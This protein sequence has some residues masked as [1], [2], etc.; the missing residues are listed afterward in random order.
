MTNSPNEFKSYLFTY[1]HDGAEWV[2]EIQAR[3]EK[4][5]IARKAKI[6][7]ARLDGELVAKIPAHVGLFA[8]AAVTLKNALKTI[9][10]PTL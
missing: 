7:Y 9:T 1:Q 10:S 2:F 5:A 6:A 4:D 8:K 3:D